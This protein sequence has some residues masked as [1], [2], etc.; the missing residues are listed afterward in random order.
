MKKF[1]FILLLGFGFVIGGNLSQAQ[2]G[3]EGKFITFNG[4]DQYI[5]IPSHSDFNIQVG[6]S[7]TLAFRMNPDNFDSIYHVL[8]KGN[9]MIPGSR[10]TFTTLKTTTAPNLS[11]KLINSHDADLSAP[12]LTTLEAGKWMHVAW[13]YNSAEKSSKVYINGFLIK[14]LEDKRLKTIKD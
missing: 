13:V 1:L 6:E 5:S 14:L 12:Y 7:F 4:L 11:L 8:T 2:V 3:P 9:D 10:Y